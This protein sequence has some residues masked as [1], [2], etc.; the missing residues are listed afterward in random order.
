MTSFRGKFQ[1][2]YNSEVI[3]VVLTA[4]DDTI[5]YDQNRE[6]NFVRVRSGNLGYVY[7]DSA[8]A[9]G[10]PNKFVVGGL[11]PLFQNKIKRFA[12]STLR[13]GYNVPNVNPYNNTGIIKIFPGGTS[14]TF[15]M[16]TGY[17]T[18][19]T[20]FMTAF[21][22]AV[23]TAIAPSSKTMTGVPL[24]TDP[25]SYT[26]T[27]SSGAFVFDVTSPMVKYG[28]FL[29]NLP[30]DQTQTST[31][32][33][34]AIQLIYTRY[35]DITSYALNQYNKNVSSS[36]NTSLPQLI[37]RLYETPFSED[38]NG[39]FIAY[40]RDRFITIQNLNWTN[41]ERDVALTSCDITLYDEFGNLLYINQNGGNRTDFY[42]SLEIAT[43][44]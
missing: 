21:L 36:G 26:L 18:T 27:L 38:Q 43:E 33:M 22:L 3:P 37:L 8:T 31:K 44:I 42:I 11:Q 13:I 25:E 34:G 17:Y 23:N 24:P 6:P 16:P 2:P 15:T 19:V 10:P 40:S 4:V 35:I 9:I 1:N 41:F 12:L 29:C 39:N 14:Y 20:S 7:L 5:Q 30:I 32:I 28:Q